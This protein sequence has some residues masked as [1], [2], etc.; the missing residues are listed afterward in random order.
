[1]LPL[2]TRVAIIGAGPAGMST[3]LALK[4]RGVT[5]ITI[6]EKEQVVGGK[7]R[8]F[9]YEGKVYDLGANLTTPRYETI[10]S[11]G[12]RMDM[13]QRKIVDRRIVNIGSEEFPSLSDAN[14]LERLVVRGG[15][16]L[17]N[18]MRHLTR[19]DRH[20]YAG[21]R[22]GVEQPFADWLR[23]HGLGRFR[24]LFEV[25]FVAYGYGRMLELPAAYALKFFDPVHM[26]AAIDVVLGKE[27]PDTKDFAE[28]FQE[29]WER[30]DRNYELGTKR[31][32]T[33]HEVHR[34]PKGVD[35]H[36]S[37]DGQEWFDRFDKLFLA[38]PLT[39]ALRFLDASPTEERLFTQIQYNDYYVTVARLEGAPD[40]STY[41]YPYARE[42]TPGQPTVFYPPVEDDD[43]LFVYYAYGGEGVTEQTVRENIDTAMAAGELSGKVAEFLHTQ[44]WRY[45]P[46]V[47]S[48]VMRAGWYD[49][50]EALQGEFHTFYTGEILSF[51]LVELVANYS[52]DLVRRFFS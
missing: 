10:R 43:G 15:A 9:E 42:F 12:E 31:G 52:R 50:L 38:C 2:T 28:G 16:S 6:F 30:V 37:Q 32:V 33:V 41:V 48:D 34:S 14:L 22:D 21:L 51:T 13:T 3:A 25:L 45:F 23:R 46:H 36:W 27:I 1:M 11:L 26:E 44:H 19:I 18:R 5:D 20:G 40:I 8:S 17:Y 7:C 4:H 49:D 35:I 24:E 39:E 47:S 29:L